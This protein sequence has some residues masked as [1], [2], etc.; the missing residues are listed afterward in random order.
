MRRL[1]GAT[2]LAVA[3]FPPAA[4]L[5]NVSGAAPAPAEEA[6]PPRAPL[7]AK[8]E[9]VEPIPAG[10]LAGRRP[11]PPSYQGKSG[12]GRGS[13]APATRTAPAGAAAAAGP[14]PASAPP[15]VVA[16]TD[17]FV[18]DGSETALAVDLADGNTIAANLNLGFLNSPSL[19]N[20]LNG[21]GSWTAR[22]FPPG[23]GVFTNY[24]FDPWASP[25]NTT[26]ELFT[27]FLRF[28]ATTPPTTARM[29]VGRSTDG[30]VSWS[31]FYE[32]VKSVDQDRDM[33]DID[34]T[35][36][37]GGGSGTA[38]DGTLYLTFDGFDSH[39]AYVASY[40]HVVSPAGAL[41]REVTTSNPNQ[42]HGSEMQPVPGINDGQVYLMSVSSNQTGDQLQLSFHEVN[43]A[44]TTLVSDKSA[45]AFYAV[46]QQLGTSGRWGVNGHRIGA[47]MQMDIDRSNGP[48]R[49]TLY[50]LSTL[51]PNHADPTMDQGDVY[52]SVSTD[53]A[54]TWVHTLIPGLAAG[55]TQFFGMLDVD[56]DGWIHVAYY[57][58]ETGS[59]DNGV[60]NAST[61]NV[62][63]TVSADG[64]LTWATHTL[65]NG[66]GDTL[67]YFDP[68]P[69]L[70]AQ[71]YYLIGDYA[72]V[73]AGRA[74]GTKVAYVFWSGY[75][76]NRD[77]IT[78]FSKRDRGICT[79]M[80]PSVDTDGDGLFDPQDNCPTIYNPGQEDLNSNGI[81]DICECF[82]TRANVDD[83]G[84]SQGRIDGSDLFPLARSFGSCQGD[85]AYDASVDLSPE[86]CVDGY[87]LALLASI[88]ADPVPAVCP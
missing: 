82:H 2:A 84:S 76:K 62:Y 33:F 54:Q 8:F 83:T 52:L 75:D 21:N 68:P 51:N 17:V 46:G 43:G 39:G 3:L 45:F 66:P 67:Q 7:R 72:Q 48:R 36:A 10:L 57:Q 59:T 30:G 9:P 1:L 20:S 85:A 69:D 29:V 77:D 11:V 78:Q 80:T 74:S 56:E 12:R 24:P 4:L 40:L 53:G 64:G 87:D 86:G 63:Y 28:N 49:G 41:L 61:A 42:F 70:L 15:I 14:V 31:R 37:Q 81:G 38:H 19:F 79:R 25:G 73:R 5:A 44:G 6:K 26:G 47:Q 65:V 22:A 55:K 18:G 13:E 34:R 35:S 32:A 16:G 88:F 58:N 27:S 50:V 71:T 23:S 60:L